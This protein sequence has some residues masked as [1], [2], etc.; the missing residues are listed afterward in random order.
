MVSGSYTC[1]TW[2]STGQGGAV[3]RYACY[4]LA[5][6]V[7]WDGLVVLA[8]HSTPSTEGLVT[9]SGKESLV[10]HEPSKFDKQR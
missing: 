1:E 10:T 7:E 4:W 9:G 2:D 3:G 5:R 8:G 6:D